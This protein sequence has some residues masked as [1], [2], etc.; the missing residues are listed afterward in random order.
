MRM[1]SVDARNPEQAIQPKISPDW[2]RGTTGNGDSRL[3]RVAAPLTPP[4]FWPE[5]SVSRIIA[6]A[7]QFLPSSPDSHGAGLLERPL[8]PLRYDGH[9]EDPHEVAGILRSLMPER[10][11][12]LDVGCGTGSVTL[13]ANASKDNVVLAIE[14]DADRCAVAVARGIEVFHGLLDQG[15][16]S[17]SG[18][19]DVVMF[20][21]VLEHLSSPDDMLG[22]AVSSLRPG[23][24]IL[25]S[26]PNVA[27]WS[28]RLNLLFGRFDYAETGLC[29]A[30]HLR[31]FTER[32][33]RN[34]F[35]HHALEIVA[36]R[37][38]AGLSLPLYHSKY[39]KYVPRSVLR[40]I[41][42][43]MTNVFPRL[44]ACQFVVMARKPL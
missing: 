32:T 8:D 34:L 26:V 43:L 21:D 38:S 2:V 22:L 28:L 13:I 33:F 5:G 39:F 11:R 15:F 20:A 40:R 27:H 14:P 12:V 42:L 1:S 17:R 31:W 4:R 19:F 25:A 29:D 30:T 9:S 10:S 36:L 3:R 6:M 16:I 37:C 41:V 24:N 44:F 7:E 18:P 23:G 35:G